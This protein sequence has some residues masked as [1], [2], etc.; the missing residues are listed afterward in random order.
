[1][2]KMDIASVGLAS[3]I[4]GTLIMVERSQRSAN[5]S[6]KRS[7][8]QEEGSAKSRWC[9]SK[10]SARMGHSGPLDAPICLVG[11][12]YGFEEQRAGRPFVGPA[13][14]LLSR[15]LVKAGIEREQC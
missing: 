14:K 12:D 6:T 10:C 3:E 2:Q 8:A 13:G 11:R 5:V 9:W 7:Y 15:A 4:D 1:M